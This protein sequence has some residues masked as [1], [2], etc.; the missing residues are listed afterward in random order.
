MVLSFLEPR[1]VYRFLVVVELALPAL[2][3]SDRIILAVSVKA[4]KACEDGLSQA[5]SIS[6]QGAWQ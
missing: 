3:F 2:S 5:A 6:Y 1:L 4:V